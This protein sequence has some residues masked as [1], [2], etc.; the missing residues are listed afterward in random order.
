MLNARRYECLSVEPTER[1]AYAGNTS[2]QISVIDVD[3]WAVVRDQQAHLGTVRAIA[4]HPALPYLAAL[5]TDRCLSLW[6]RHVGTG[7]LAPLAAVSIRD[8]ACSNDE[9]GV[10]LAQ[11]GGGDRRAEREKHQQRDKRFHDCA[12]F[13][14]TGVT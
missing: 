11:L 6:Q 5:G 9:F 10:P 8:V 4:V 14:S 1:W 7:R 12:R 13:T 3:T 2:G